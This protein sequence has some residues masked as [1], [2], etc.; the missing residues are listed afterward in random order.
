MFANAFDTFCQSFEAQPIRK[1][2]NRRQHPV[3]VFVAID[4]GDKTAVDL[5]SMDLEPTKRGDGGMTGAEIVKVDV[6][7]NVAE[8]NN[9]SGNDAFW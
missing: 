1:P 7:A 2:E 8:L 3:L 5:Q 9:V 6:A 4:A